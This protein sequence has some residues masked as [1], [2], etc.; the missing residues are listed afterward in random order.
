MREWV[1]IVTYEGMGG[2]GD[3]RECVAIVTYEGMGG[4]GG[5]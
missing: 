5:T 1:A 4:N 3:M 2:N